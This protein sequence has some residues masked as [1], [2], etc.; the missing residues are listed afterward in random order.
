MKMTMILEMIHCSLLRSGATPDSVFQH[1][2]GCM[3]NNKK[4]ETLLEIETSRDTYFPAAVGA[5][6]LLQ[7][8][9][10][11]PPAC[12]LYNHNLCADKTP[13]SVLL[14]FTKKR[15]NDSAPAARPHRPHT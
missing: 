7:P 13:S 3:G 5:P 10:Y 4:G 12:D 6:T 8:S 2:V 9:S 1:N 11:P 14:L 15:L